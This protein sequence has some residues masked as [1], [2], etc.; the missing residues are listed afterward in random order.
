MTG[1]LLISPRCAVRQLDI[2][3]EAVINCQALCAVF[4]FALGFADV[5][6]VNL[7]R[8]RADVVVAASSAVILRAVWRL[9]MIMLL[10][11]MK[12]LPCTYLLAFSPQLHTA[13][14]E[15]KK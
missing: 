11:F 12:H 8:V 10:M 9:K 15:A 6:V 7:R 2:A 5:D 1:E 3:C 14:I 13:T 4:A